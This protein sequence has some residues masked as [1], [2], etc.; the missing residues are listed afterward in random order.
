LEDWIKS[1]VHSD[2]HELFTHAEEVVGE[3]SAPKFKPIHCSK[4]EVATWLAWQKRPGHGLYLVVEDELIDTNSA[5]FEEFSV[6][7]TH[8]YS[9][10]D[11]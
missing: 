6:W 8:I 1:C 11:K 5:L 4:A 10:E 2:E 9:S 3:L 7:L